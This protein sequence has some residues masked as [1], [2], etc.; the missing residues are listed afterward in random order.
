MIFSA[1]RSDPFDT[2]G[3]WLQLEALVEWKKR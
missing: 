1:Q 3:G 2:T